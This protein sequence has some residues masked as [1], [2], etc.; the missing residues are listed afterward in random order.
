M[1]MNQIKGGAFLSYLSIIISIG[2]SFVYTP[3]MLKRMGQSEYGLFSLALTIV[4]YLS[5]M[6]FG[7]GAAIVR[8]SGIYKNGNKNRL[9]NLYGLFIRMY[10]IIGLV[11]LMCG[12]ILFYLTPI[13]FS[14]SLSQTELMK[15]KTIVL[16]IIIYLSVSF[17]FSV[18]SAIITSYEKFIFLKTMN[19]VRS[20]LVPILMIPLLLL[21]YKSIAMTLITVGVGLL[22]NIV[23][24][25]FCF[26]KLDVKFLFDKI[27]K[28]LMFSILGFSILVFGKD[29]FERI[30]WSSGQFIIGANLGTIPV[31]IFAIALQM[32][33]YYETFSKTIS[34][35]FFPRVV[36]LMKNSNFIQEFQ[37]LFIKIG[38]IQFHLLAY[39]LMIYLLIGEYFIN[40]WAG[41]NYNSAYKM[42]LLIM[43][44]YTFPLIQSLGGLFLQATGKLKIQL[45]IYITE[46]VLVILFSFILTKYIGLYGAA[47]SLSIGIII[48]EIILAN[49]YWKLLKIKIWEFWL[50][51]LKIMIP[52]T[53]FVILGIFIMSHF[54]IDSYLYIIISVCF[55]SIVYFIYIYFF[56]MN[57]YE[58]NLISV[59][60]KRI[61]KK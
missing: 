1:G 27:N 24:V 21:G 37:L 36:S 46:S 7:F 61:L 59:T 22:I 49:I 31:A 4:S 43:I 3:F 17:P 38:R 42:S 14:N 12:I 25:V 54:N 55:I 13:L 40:I 41:K 29:F 50:E 34:N 39:I 47:I 51:I 28:K 60:F 52:F 19:I 20:L 18:F 44:P 9:Y 45:Y 33:G 48:S 53:L 32:K 26:R 56:A 23:N 10:S 57:E 16:I 2:V 11:C 5:L 6:D 15:L 30:T 58:K 35:L 8:Y